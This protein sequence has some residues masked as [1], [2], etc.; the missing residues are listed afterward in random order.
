MPALYV[1]DGY[2]KVILVTSRMQEIRASMLDTSRHVV[3]F[4]PYVEAMQLNMSM[5]YEFYT[6]QFSLPRWQTK[7]RKGSTNSNI[8]VC[9][10]DNQHILSRV[11]EP[12]TPMGFTMKEMFN[13]AGLT[14]DFLDTR[15]DNRNPHLASLP[16]VVGAVMIVKADCSSDGGVY[17]QNPQLR[18]AMSKDIDAV[19]T[20]RFH[21]HED[22]WG[23][24][25]QLG[26]ESTSGKA[27][28][29]GTAGIQFVV[30]S[31]G[32]F[33]YPDPYRT[34]FELVAVI[35]IMG[36]PKA[37]IVL[38]MTCCLG[39]LSTVYKRAIHRP[40]NFTEELAVVGTRLLT[41][42]YAF[43]DLEDPSN[44]RHVAR[45]TVA[46]QLEQTMQKQG[47][48]PKQADSF[49]SL[50]WKAIRWQ[51]NFNG[52]L[53]T[54]SSKA[55]T[56]NLYDAASKD[57]M[58]LIDDAMTLFELQRKRCFCEQVFLPDNVRQVL[59]SFEAEDYEVEASG[60]S[61]WT[62][63]SPMGSAK[64]PRS[65][66]H[67]QDSQSPQLDGRSPEEIC[68]MVPLTVHAVDKLN[69]AVQ[70][71]VRE[72]LKSTMATE[73]RVKEME[74]RH[75]AEIRSLRLSLKQAMEN[76]ESVNSHDVTPRPRFPSS[77]SKHH[78]MVDDH[79]SIQALEARVA[80]LAEK[81]VHSN[82]AE[83]RMT[84][85][86]T[87]IRELQGTVRKIKTS[88]KRG[89]VPSSFPPSPKA[90]TEEVDHRLA[91]KGAAS[92]EVDHRLAS[93]G[94]ASQ[95][96]D[97]RLASKGAASQASAQHDAPLASVSPL[98]A[99]RNA[100]GY[101]S[102]DVGGSV[103]RTVGGVGVAAWGASSGSEDDMIPAEGR[104][105]RLCSNIDV[106][107]IFSEDGCWSRSKSSRFRS[108]SDLR[109]LSRSNSSAS[110]LEQQVQQKRQQAQKDQQHQ[111]PQQD[112]H[113]QQQHQ[114]PQQDQQQQQP[115]Q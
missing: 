14:G 64:S 46:W 18:K 109:K 76:R 36:I 112:Q 103:S 82:M 2:G 44:C 15:E 52:R 66:F 26:F 8:L 93:K 99:G 60:T 51:G 70:E 111:Q 6:W 110:D 87:N 77:P 38:F 4:S 21:V 61:S 20:L 78:D 115:Q 67:H 10:F 49:V 42:S 100:T 9:V 107:G 33:T 1:N 81:Q 23:M 27:A 39:H 12:G 40:L 95:V 65:H 73:M 91:S 56:L 89:E 35:V 53:D 113:D 68:G 84:S 62:S 7:K 105:A 79:N 94:A 13:L 80:E 50:L 41:S 24:I 108:L 22:E 57:D 55:D 101:S 106:A 90:T 59:T 32:S 69:E 11:F 72:I 5:S 74:H 75:H 16:R 102:A 92:Q 58:L 114:Q 43:K 31:T 48:E 37:I 34:F 17:S 47:M 88:M 85:M 3:Q 104:H 45:N 25:E 19:C 98:R 54:T 97:Q 30:H 71:Q 83:H 63:F 86:E 96:A 29:R 28:A